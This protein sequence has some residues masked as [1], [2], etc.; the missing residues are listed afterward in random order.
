MVWLTRMAL[1]VCWRIRV[2]RSASDDRLLN[3]AKD[4]VSFCEGSRTV[5]RSLA[6]LCHCVMFRLPR[7]VK[8]DSSYISYKRLY[9][10]RDIDRYILQDVAKVWVR[11]A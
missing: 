3:L 11:C 9:T 8:L 7:E 6:V 1:W 2:C 5:G 10:G 4:Y